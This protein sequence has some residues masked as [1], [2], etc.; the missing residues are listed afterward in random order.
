MGGKVHNFSY[1]MKYM[2][3]KTQEIQVFEQDTTKQIYKTHFN[4]VQKDKD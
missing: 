1:L 4:Q 3:L 2:N